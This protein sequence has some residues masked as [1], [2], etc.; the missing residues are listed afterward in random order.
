MIRTTFCTITR[1]LC[2]HAETTSK[3]LGTPSGASL[4]API[5]ELIAK[6]NVPQSSIRHRIMVA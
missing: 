4:G 5:A 1:Y 3:P 6:K 2:C